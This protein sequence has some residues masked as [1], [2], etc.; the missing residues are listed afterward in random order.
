MSRRKKRNG[1]TKGGSDSGRR[2]PKFAGTMNDRSGGI[3]PGLTLAGRGDYTQTHKSCPFSLFV[4][5]VDPVTL[6]VV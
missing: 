2:T 5:N 1:R 3:R 4:L 6:T